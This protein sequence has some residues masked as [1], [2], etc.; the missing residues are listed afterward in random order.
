MLNFGNLKFGHNEPGYVRLVEIRCYF[1]VR[2]VNVRLSQVRIINGK[3][4]Q[5]FEDN[6]F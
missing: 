1:L 4:G 5:A 3:L 6:E 2:R